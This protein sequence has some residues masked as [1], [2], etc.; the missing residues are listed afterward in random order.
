M[1]APHVSGV[2][3]LYLGSHHRAGPKEVRQ[4]I[5]HNASEDKIVGIGPGSPNKLLWSRID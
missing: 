4:A 2:A 5:R 1:S 3:A